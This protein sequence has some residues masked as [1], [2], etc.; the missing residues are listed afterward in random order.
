MISLALSASAGGYGC[1]LRLADGT[2]RE[3][4]Q[5]DD[6]ATPVARLF[7]RC[8]IAPSELQQI[9]IDIGPGSYTGLRVATSFANALRAFADVAVHTAS[10]LELLALAAFDAD[11]STQQTP[12]RPVLDAR[13]HRVH[14]SLLHLDTTLE[15]LQPPRATTGEELQAL[16]TSNERLL[17]QESV[18]DLITPFATKAELQ[19][20]CLMPLEPMSLALR[21]FDPRLTLRVAATV[22]ELQPLYLMGSYAD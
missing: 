6:L 19:V 18:R 16:L 2:V 21:L 12:L 13:R 10:S 15:M 11:P 9:I 22:D 7:D 4:Q 20:A 14:H 17:V 5:R 1:A 3:E 8:R